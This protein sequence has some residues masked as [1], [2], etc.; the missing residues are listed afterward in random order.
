MEPVSFEFFSW[1]LG[2]VSLVLVGLV[3]A[4][5]VLH[6]RVNA[7]KAELAAYKLQV[8]EKYVSQG[9]LKEVEERLTG[10]LLRIE[11][12]LDKVKP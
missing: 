10:H 9:H 1:T 2:F 11:A 5:M 3:K 4:N 12:Q 7:R 8:A 6:R